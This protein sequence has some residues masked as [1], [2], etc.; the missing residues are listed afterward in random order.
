MEIFSVF[1]IN[2][3][4]RLPSVPPD[5]KCNRLHGHTFRIEVHV[6]GETEAA[7]GWVTDF[8]DI[9]QAFQPL[10]ERLDHAHL[11]EIDG[12]SNP[13]SENLARWIWARLIAALPGLCRIVVQETPNVGCI[14]EGEGD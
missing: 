14:Y 8:A 1:F 11:N 9:D 6:R 3:A 5:H 10:Y 13:T 2:A 4:H 12:L 7:S